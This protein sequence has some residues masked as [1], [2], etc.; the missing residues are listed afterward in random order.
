MAIALRKPTKSKGGRVVNHQTDGRCGT[1]IPEGDGGHGADGRGETGRKTSRRRWYWAAGI[2]FFLTAGVLLWHARAGV[3][4]FSW[5]ALTGKPVAVINGDP[6]PR[7]EFRE[8]LAISRIM[9][10]RQYG[11]DLFAGEKGR[12]LQ[13]DLERDVLEKMLEDRLVAQEARRLNV[14]VS[15]E[16]VR[17]EMEAIGREIYGSPEK[18][19]ATLKDDGIPKQYLFDHIRNLILRQ[20][21]AKGKTPSGADTDESLGVWLIQARQDAGVTVYR[22]VGSS[23]SPSP[24]GSSCCGSGGGGSGG[25]M[26]GCGVSGAP[27]GAVD[28]EL[29]GAASAAALAEYRKINPAGQGVETR[30][31]DYG[32]HIQVDI[33]QGGKV[34]RSYTYQDG[35]AF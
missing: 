35:K 26:D 9:L 16:R 8:R 30:V 27:A 21:V 11:K 25:G 29:K 24:G 3:W 12:A 33:E 28:P 15:D 19:Q 2:G 31:I 20:E 1:E 14:R 23:R 18:F 5:D 32:C 17:E 22:A 6:V 10:E 4:D 34:V 13:A 7:Q